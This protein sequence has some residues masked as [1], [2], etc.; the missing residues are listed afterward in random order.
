MLPGPASYAT[1]EDLIK[2][3]IS[4]WKLPA[5]KCAND[6]HDSLLKSLVSNSSESVLNATIPAQFPRLRKTIHQL[7]ADHMM[8]LKG[9]AL[10]R[11]SEL[12]EMEKTLYTSNNDD[13]SE[14]RR[15]FQYLIRSLDAANGME[16]KV[17]ALS[18][19][20]QNHLSS[21]LMKLGCSKDDLALIPTNN[22]LDEEVS[23]LFIGSCC[24]YTTSFVYSY[25]KLS[26]YLIRLE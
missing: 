2:E 10:S 4:K 8:K 26:T 22:A 3:S 21:I 9:K 7:V 20:D 19:N 24:R 1:S 18:P 16:S 25:L 23:L 6:V 11:I 12:L 15:K 5:Q 13:L 14:N 17:A